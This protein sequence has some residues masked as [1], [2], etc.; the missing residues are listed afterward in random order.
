MLATLLHLKTPKYY[1]SPKAAFVLRVFGMTL[2][3][4]AGYRYQNEMLRKRK[5][6]FVKTQSN[7]R[8]AA[9]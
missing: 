1:F 7:S 5:N 9:Q 3:A 8:N 2:G 4:W 6:E